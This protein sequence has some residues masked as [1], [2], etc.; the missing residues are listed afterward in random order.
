[1]RMALPDRRPAT[2][3]HVLALALRQASH[4]DHDRS[5]RPSEITADLLPTGS[6]PEPFGVD[7]A[8]EPRQSGTRR[9]NREQPAPGEISEEG[10]HIDP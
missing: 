4:A 3:E 2:D 7:T 5:I 1:M 10:Q 6:G 9:Y 8:G